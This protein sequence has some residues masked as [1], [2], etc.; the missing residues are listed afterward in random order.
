[1]SVLRLIQRCAEFIPRGEVRRVP[2]RRRGIYVLYRQRGYLDSKRLQPRRD[3][4]Y[5]GMT[6]F[7][8]RSRLYSHARSKRKKGWSHFSVYEAWP[9]ITEQEIRELE[10]LFRHIYRTD[11][12][13]NMLNLQRG[14]RAIRKIREQDLRKW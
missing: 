12:R 6:D 1:M 8:I 9:N 3:V 14:F 13:A 7:S 10:G 2:R 4:L 11:G 5:V